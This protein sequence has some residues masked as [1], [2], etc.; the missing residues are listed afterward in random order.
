MES[1]YVPPPLH[2]LPGAYPT[3]KSGAPSSEDGDL[4]IVPRG[5]TLSK[6]QLGATDYGRRIMRIL[7]VSYWSP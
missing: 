1:I 2:L 4:P 3:L 6:I 5:L 7:P